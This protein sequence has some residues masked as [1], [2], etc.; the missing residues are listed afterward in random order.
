MTKI[1]L[2]TLSWQ[3]GRN[4]FLG[5][6]YLVVG[7][8]CFAIV[9]VFLILIKFK[10]RYA[11]LLFLLRHTFGPSASPP[12][13]GLVVQCSLHAGKSPGLGAGLH[14]RA[15]LAPHSGAVSLLAGGK[16]RVPAAGFLEHFRS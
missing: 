4:P 11:W 13:P 5:I 10:G 16:G 15:R 2:S 7:G 8:L 9:G 6:C 14:Q 12:L 1:V 3:G